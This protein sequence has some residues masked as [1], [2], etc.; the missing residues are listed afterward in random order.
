MFELLVVGT[1]PAGLAT[2][3]R[4]ARQGLQVALAYPSVDGLQS[5]PFLSAALRELVPELAVDRLRGHGPSSRNR[6]SIERL[7]RI[8][9]NRVEDVAARQL[10][11]VRS[12]GV[13]LFRGQTRFMDEHTVE[14]AGMNSAVLLRAQC[15]AVATGSTFAD[16]LRNEQLAG[17]ILN[18]DQI[19]H[20]ES[21]PS[22]LVVVGSDPSGVEFASLFAVGGSRV[23][24][25]DEKNHAECDNLHD[26]SLAL[27]VSFRYGSEVVGIE[28]L[29]THAPPELVSLLLGDGCRLI[30]DRVLVAGRRVGRTRSLDLNAAGLTTDDCYRLWC[31][32][33][34]R[35]WQPHIYGVG[36]V[37]G[38]SPHELNAAAQARTVVDAIVQPS[39]VPAPIGLGRS[40]ARTHAQLGLVR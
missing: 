27:G 40:K 21:V 4:A 18:A 8:V 24:V 14:V 9:I 12:A 26:I 25:L 36:E 32:H 38:F 31:D 13:E 30:G 1:D 15:I 2:A 10:A 34:Q 39:R 17:Q 33:Q 22:K 11:D 29:N 28:T 37:V 19:L 20:V 23:V 35:T 7:R 3:T 5:G 16:D 6:L